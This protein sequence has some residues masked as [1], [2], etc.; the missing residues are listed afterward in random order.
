MNQQLLNINTVISPGIT[1]LKIH[2]HLAQLAQLAQLADENNNP[3]RLEQI[4][5][6]VN[7]NN[8]SGDSSG[9]S[10]YKIIR[11]L[12][13]GIH[14]NLYLATDAAGHRVI[15]KEIQLDSTPANNTMQRKQ[16]N[17]ELNILKYLS[18]N[19]VAREHINPCLDYKIHKDYVYTI[20]PVFRGY[21][22]GH[23]HKYM[24]K[25]KE[26]EQKQEQEQESYY[27]I[28]FYLIKSL[29]HA[30]AKIHD[31]GI[32]HQNINLN[33][34]LVSTFIKPNEIKVKLT[35]FG[36]GCGCPKNADENIQTSSNA[37]SNN[38]MIPLQEYNMLISKIGNCKENGHAPVKYM[39]T[40]LEH[41]KNSDYLKISQRYDI[42][43][44]GLIML[45]FLL[46]FD[47]EIISII[48][49][50]IADKNKDN[51]RDTDRDT[52]RDEELKM[53]NTI[54]AM[55]R[56]KI[57]IKCFDDKYMDSLLANSDKKIVLEYL[58]LIYKYMISLTINRRPAQYIIDKI[59]IYEKYKNDIF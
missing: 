27:K 57:K 19:T 21:S 40:V 58:K 1:G 29:L 32:A 24:L 55:L 9:N 45:K 39:K 16:L 51:D 13:R 6:I 14:G 38:T 22:L 2:N 12:G 52:D 54:L 48:D 43:C 11:Y 42:L 15:C 23:F 18:S 26:Q 46:Y 4:E 47:T 25:L 53:N 41:L 3:Q 37:S 36:L 20:F 34:V 31:T 17:F 30:L 35:D 50:L 5:S 28:A 44:L 49:N 7:N 56:D 8:S 10:R 33:N 59:I